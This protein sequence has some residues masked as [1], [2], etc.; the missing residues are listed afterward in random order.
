MSQLAQCVILAPMQIPKNLAEL[1]SEPLHASLAAASMESMN[2]LNNIAGNYPEA[3]SF[4]AGRPYEGFFDTDQIHEYLRV[5]AGYLRSERH[6]TEQQVS[7]TLLQYGDTKGVITELI[8]RNL[9]VDEDIH[10]DPRGVVVTVGF[11]E[12]LFLVLRTLRADDRDALLAPSPTYV[13]LTGAA[14]LTD[15]PVLSVPSGEHGLDLGEL[16]RRLHAARDAGH[17]VRACYVTPD[18]ANPV[19][20]SM[21]VDDRHRLLEIAAAEGLLL[22]EDNP[23]GLFHRIPDRRPPTLKSLDTEGRVV[24]LGSFA[25]SGVAGARVG[26]AV[27]DQPV[28]GG[29]LADELSKI[30]SMLT[31]NTSP[32]AQAVIGGK[33]IANDFSLVAANARETAVYQSNLTQVLQGLAKRFRDDAG[34]TWNEPDGGFFVVVTVPFTVDDAF[35]EHA[36]R[37]HGVLFTPMHHFFGAGTESRQLRLSIS[38]LTPERIEEGLDRLAAAVTSRLPGASPADATAGAVS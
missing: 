28:R 30:K 26:F 13:G 6:M 18:F 11:Q 34:V 19:G 35:L 14:L 21:T 20:V 8:A 37:E 1:S 38:T 3:I 33:L 22:L 15:L 36:A 7:R 25:K 27:A 29:L 16:V 12:A 4:A 32:I 17:R 31:V 5:F 2:L 24:Y 23:Y 10:V 9:A